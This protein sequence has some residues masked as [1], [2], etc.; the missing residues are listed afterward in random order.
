MRK[1]GFY[2]KPTWD[3]AYCDKRT[4][5][6]WEDEEITTAEACRRV[7]RNNGL[8]KTITAQQLYDFAEACGYW[9]FRDWK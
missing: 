3:Y 6:L 5:S 4:L 7:S 9:Y 2:P 8:K 1:Y